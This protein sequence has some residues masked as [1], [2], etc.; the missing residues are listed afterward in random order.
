[1]IRCGYHTPHRRS[2]SENVS[3]LDVVSSLALSVRW[4]GWESAHGIPSSFIFSTLIPLI[5]DFEFLFSY[6]NRCGRGRWCCRKGMYVLKPVLTFNQLLNPISLSTS[7]S[8]IQPFFLLSP[9]LYPSGL[10]HSSIDEI[11]RH[12]FSFHTLQ[13]HFQENTFQ[14]YST[15]IRRRFVVFPTIPRSWKSIGVCKLMCSCSVGDLGFE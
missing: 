9:L 2:S 8:N 13:T 10:D 5:V 14:Q 6:S 1:V 12:V 15:I 4:T 7:Y 11:I 3:G